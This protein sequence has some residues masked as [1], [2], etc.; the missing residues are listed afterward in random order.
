MK[1]I[2]T[3]I[4]VF[5]VG[6]SAIYVSERRRESTPVSANAV[7][8]VAADAQRDLTRLPMRLT[9][10]SDQEEVAI[11]DELAKQYSMDEEKLSPEDLA[12]EDRKSVV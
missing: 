9:R 12:L 3:F 10:L 5:F 8:E 7:I 2:A 6:V 1:R 11:G 4:A